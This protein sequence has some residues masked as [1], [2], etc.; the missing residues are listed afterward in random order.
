MN[1]VSEL[2]LMKVA[3]VG[4]APWVL[5]LREETYNQRV[6]S[7]NPGIVYWIDIFHIKL[8]YKLYWFIEKDRK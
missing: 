8:L 7:S 5:W 1:Y 6:V 3:N 4:C 2:R